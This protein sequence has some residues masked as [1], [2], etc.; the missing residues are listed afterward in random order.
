[1]GPERFHD[2]V[3]NIPSIVPILKVNV[4]NYVGLLLA[5]YSKDPGSSSH[6]FKFSLHRI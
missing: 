5:K 4:G 2:R 6:K 1:M 3:H